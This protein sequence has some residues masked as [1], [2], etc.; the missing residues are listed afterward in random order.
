MY[1]QHKYLNTPIAMLYILSHDLNYWYDME[2]RKDFMVKFLVVVW[3]LLVF[4]SYY[5][6]E[7]TELLIYL[8]V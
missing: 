2:L 7:I 3:I 5:Y 8:G 4:I 6:Y 1:L